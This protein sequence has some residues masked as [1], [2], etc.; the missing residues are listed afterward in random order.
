MS[1][2][3]RKQ[4]EYEARQGTASKVANYIPEPVD[5][6]SVMEIL[7]DLSKSNPVAYEEA[8]DKLI[9]E[10]GEEWFKKLRYDWSI[11]GRPKQ[12]PPMPL[13]KWRAWVCLAGRGWGKTKTGGNTVAMWV[14]LHKKGQPPIRIA[15][16]GATTGDVNNVMVGGDSGLM[17]NYPDDEQPEW[18]TTSRKI[19]WRYPDG[20]IKAIAEMFSAEEP[21][22]LRGPQFH[23]AWCDELVAW[24]YQE[25][26]DMLMFGLRLGDN[27]QVVVTTTP[28]PYP[29][30]MELL[31]LKTTFTTIGSTY[32]NRSNLAPA[33]FTEIITKY[34]GSA[35]GRQELM[36][37]IIEEVPNAMWSPKNIDANRIPYD[38]MG[39]LPEFLSI[40]LAIDPATTNR[41]SSAETGMCVA[42]YGEN[43]HFYI[44][45]LDAVKMS[46]E[47]WA[48][49]SIRLFNQYGCDKMI[50][51]V[52]NGG[53]LVQALIKAVNPMQKVY[54]VHASRGKTTRAEP[55]AALYEQN[56]VHHIGSFVSGESQMCSFNPLENPYGL[57]DQV[58]AL[59]WAMTWLVDTTQGKNSYKPVVGGK[60]QKIETYKNIFRF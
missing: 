30:L 19:T 4:D 6:R 60:R 47:N 11:N 49:R 15:L 29:I 59:V 7:A 16:V 24:R 9:E 12:F 45:H 40:V 26:W 3:Q 31:K 5:N 33:F 56:R 57:K 20:E 1:N 21:N 38:D 27:P 8:I 52:N 17:S 37:E 25:A 51:E 13:N 50:A 39:K 44:L 32:E 36:A 18:T 46:P 35:L 23:Y 53:D 55:I 22:R 14:N 58:D 10:K 41:T 42:A 2:L 43:D 54:A 34:E 48:Q 28:R